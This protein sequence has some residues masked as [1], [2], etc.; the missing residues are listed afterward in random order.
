MIILTDEQLNELLEK[1]ERAVS[2]PWFPCGARYTMIS[3]ESNSQEIEDIAEVCNHYRDEWQVENNKQFI[4]SCHPET[5]KALVM[6]LKSLRAKPIALVPS[7]EDFNK[8][9][10]ET[11]AYEPI[12][13]AWNATM[14]KAKPIQPDQWRQIREALKAFDDCKLNVNH[15]DKPSWDGSTIVDFVTGMKLSKALT[16][17]EDIEGN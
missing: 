8:E 2:G 3:R 13:A 16:I 14:A 1:A 15:G 17:I 12:Q 4:A 9:F 5:I 10:L 11:E 7:C 6:E